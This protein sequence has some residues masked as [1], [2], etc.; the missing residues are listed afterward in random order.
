MPTATNPPLNGTMSVSWPAASILLS[1]ASQPPAPRS[2]QICPPKASRVAPLGAL[3]RYP[4][5]TVAFGPT[6]SDVAKG[7]APPLGKAS[8]E[9]S[10]QRL[11]ESV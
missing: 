1:M 8:P 9:A 2:S 11:A 10:C 7:W 6:A 5:A 4:A 3:W